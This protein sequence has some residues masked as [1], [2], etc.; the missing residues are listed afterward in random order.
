MTRKRKNPHAVA[1]GRKGGALK[2]PAITR[3]AQENA[4][5]RRR[6]DRAQDTA[7]IHEARKV[8]ANPAK[9]GPWTTLDGTPVPTPAPRRGKDN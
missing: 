9:Y 8:L 2:N 1:L 7:D 6:R 3:V 5:T 4:A